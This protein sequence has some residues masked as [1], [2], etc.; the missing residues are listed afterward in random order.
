M[1]DAPKNVKL[2]LIGGCRNQ[3]D[4]DR[5][6]SLTS[7]AK[8]LGISDHVQV[9]V[10]APFSDVVS[11]LGASV[12]GLHSMTDEH[13]GISVVEYLAACCIPI[14]HDSGTCSSALTCLKFAITSDKLAASLRALY[15]VDYCAHGRD[16]GLDLQP[17]WMHSQLTSF[18][19]TLLHGAVPPLHVPV[20]GQHSG[21]CRLER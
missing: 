19:S 7:I 13:F 10:N 1:Q 2:V 11:V 9:M 3:G 8:E 12:A 6:A 17:S 16:G 5:A 18:N 14:A 15:I 4:Y 20:C 21:G